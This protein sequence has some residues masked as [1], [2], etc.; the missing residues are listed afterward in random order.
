MEVKATIRIN[1]HDN[2]VSISD[3]G[4]MRIYDLVWQAFWF[5]GPIPDDLDKYE[6]YTVE[7]ER[8]NRWKLLRRAKLKDS[9]IIIVNRPLGVG[10]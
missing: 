4:W 8:L 5:L 2:P 7:G 9:C 10:A 6:L 3:D 1:G